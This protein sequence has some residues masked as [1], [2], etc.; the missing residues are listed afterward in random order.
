MENIE[1][2]YAKRLEANR[3]YRLAHK[4]VLAEKAK[5]F[6]LQNREKILEKQRERNRKECDELKK[7]RKTLHEEVADLIAGYEQR[8]AE[9]KRMLP[10]A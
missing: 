6:Y 1:E 10:D 3:R 2:R 9:L 8:I 7:Y 5:I 4:E